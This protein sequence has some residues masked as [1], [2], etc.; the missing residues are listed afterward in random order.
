METFFLIWCLNN[1]TGSPRYMRSFYLR[2]RGYAIKK[3]PLFWNLSSD[4][5]SPLVFLYANSLYA[6]LFFEF[7]SLA[8][9]EV[10]LYLKV[11]FLSLKFQITKLMYW[12]KFNWEK[13]LFYLTSLYAFKINVSMFWENVLQHSVLRKQTS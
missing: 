3:W 1:N 5:Q 11:K 7:L 8:Y 9:N 10:H 12:M 13:L 6:S 2:F 4:L